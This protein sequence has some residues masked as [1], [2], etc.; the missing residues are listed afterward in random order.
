[1][2]VIYE[3]QPSELHRHFELIKETFARGIVKTGRG[4]RLYQQIIPKEYRAQ[5]EK[6]IEMSRTKLKNPRQMTADEI[7]AMRYLI[8]YCM[9]L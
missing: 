9:S 5:A 6:V 3:L 8:D 7:L 4:K 2:N 1:M